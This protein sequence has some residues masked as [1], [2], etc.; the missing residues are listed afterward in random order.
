MQVL[1]EVDECDGE[2]G[3]AERRRREREREREPQGGDDERETLRWL[4]GE[5]GRGRV[6]ALSFGK[7]NLPFYFFFWLVISAGLEPST[8]RAVQSKI[9]K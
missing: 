9:R 2:V 3:C 6:L 5:I 7:E 8:A 4:V 1:I